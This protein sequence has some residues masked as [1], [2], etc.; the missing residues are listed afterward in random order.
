MSRPP[1]LGHDR[2]GVPPPRSIAQIEGEIGRIRDELDRTLDALADKLAWR[3]LLHRGVEMITGFIGAA[4]RG[5]SGRGAGRRVSPIAIGM[6]GAG[7]AWAVADYAG[8][9]PGAKPRPH[10]GASPRIGDPLHCIGIGD[11][12]KP[13]SVS[14]G[15]RPR[16]QWMGRQ[17]EANPLAI[18]LL[19]LVAG[20]A[21]SAL[22]PP[23]EGEREFV[24]RA[25]ENLWQKAEDFGHRAAAQLRSTADCP[26]RRGVADRR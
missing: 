11:P 3:P 1:S 14:E 10:Q 23:T 9:L 5:K 8:V 21:A 7:V 25:R 17:L 16:G 26:S 18:G 12:R 6:I 22:L 24:D 13:E 15:V 4:K 19:G 2:N 20:A